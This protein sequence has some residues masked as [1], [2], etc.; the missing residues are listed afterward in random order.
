MG[1]NVRTYR[2]LQNR[3][4]LERDGPSGVGVAPKCYGSCPVG[5][6]GDLRFVNMTLASYQRSFL[7]DGARLWPAGITDGSANSCVA[8][9]APGWYKHFGPPS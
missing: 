4:A 9:D 2:W 1:C 3:G 7:P 8:G 6:F 5:C